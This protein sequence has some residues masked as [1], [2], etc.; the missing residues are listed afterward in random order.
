M[1]SVVVLRERHHGE[2]IDRA[3][4]T[5]YAPRK[6]RYCPLNDARVKM[7]DEFDDLIVLLKSF[8]R[9]QTKQS[10]EIEWLKEIVLKLRRRLNGLEC[11]QRALHLMTDEFLLHA[12]RRDDNTALLR[13]FFDA[14]M[15]R[16]DLLEARQN[17]SKLSSVRAIVQASFLSFE[18]RLNQQFY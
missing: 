10:D 5:K 12:A 16:I 15:A 18:Q 1:V 8:S 13:E 7:P 6:T 3:R 4:A 17:T 11:E 2:C 14:V 9:D